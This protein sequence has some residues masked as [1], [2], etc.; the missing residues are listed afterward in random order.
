MKRVAIKNIETINALTK[1][2]M[3]LEAEKDVESELL[4]RNLEYFLG[5]KERKRHSD[6]K[7]AVCI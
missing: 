3:Q 7:N 6:S 5:S 2:N 4:D 1:K